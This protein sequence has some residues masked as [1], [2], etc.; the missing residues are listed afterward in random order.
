MCL[1]A[2]SVDLNM[3]MCALKAAGKAPAPVKAPAPAPASASSSSDDSS[4][5]EE[6]AAPPSKKPKAGIGAFEPL[7][8]YKDL[9]ESKLG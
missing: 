4:D 8:G 6:E 9:M 1:E 7:R 3:F 2:G 5:D